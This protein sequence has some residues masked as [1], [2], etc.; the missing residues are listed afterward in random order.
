MPDSKY[1]RYREIPNAL[2]NL[3]ATIGETPGGGR[4]T[5]TITDGFGE[6]RRP[7]MISK[8]SARRLA[9]EILEM[10]G[11]AYPE[12]ILNMGDEVWLAGGPDEDSERGPDE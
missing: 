4:L 8:D 11:V 2:G 6:I 5:I 1:G 12:M 10:T 7:L 3:M 9:T